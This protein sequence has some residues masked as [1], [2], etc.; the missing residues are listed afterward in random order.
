METARIGFV[1]CG[2]F[3]TAAIYPSLRFA[4]LDLVAVCSRQAGKA[5]RTARTFGAR[6]WYTNYREMLDRE[7]LDGVICIT[8]GD[9][10][11]MAM[12][13]LERGLNVFIEKPPAPDLA[14][15]KALRQAAEKAGRWVQVGFMKRF[16][17]S[18]RRVREIICRT[19]GF[20]RPTH[21][22][23]KFS[24]GSWTADPWDFAAGMTIHFAD[25]F[26]FLLGEV[27]EVTA[28]RLDESGGV[29]LDAI[30]RFAGGAVGVLTSG[31]HLDWYGHEERLEVSGQGAQII[32]DN[33]TNVTYYPRTGLDGLG[34][35]ESPAQ[36]WSPGYTAI[37]EQNETLF[38]LGYV[39]E[40]RH[41]AKCLCEETT[42]EV[43]A[44]D[45]YEAMRICRALVDSEG[46]PV[47]L[48]PAPAGA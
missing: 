14:G 11:L 6:R 12:E 13:A 36:V 21:I 10:H 38:L 40:M 5:E 23:G 44:A 22:L 34:L 20:G 28:Y 31:E 26:R 1:G 35:A 15:A 3:A 7:E 2:R 41:F 46:T 48:V 25:L 32:V 33:Y 9:Q 8:G 19:E 39:Q 16:A 29:T 18:Y 47:R 45:A 42:P 43:T 30:L 27:E 24:G 17:P 37:G 4:P